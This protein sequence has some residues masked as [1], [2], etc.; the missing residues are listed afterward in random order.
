[1]PEAPAE[2]ADGELGSADLGPSVSTSTAG[3]RDSARNRSIGNASK[4][5]RTMVN[6]PKHRCL[7]GIRPVCNCPGI[8][9][10]V[11]SHNR[12]DPVSRCD[13]KIAG[14]EQRMQGMCVQLVSAIRHPIILQD[15]QEHN[16]HQ[17]LADPYGAQNDTGFARRHLPGLLAWRSLVCKE[18]L[19]RGVLPEGRQLRR[20]LSRN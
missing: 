9:G 1:M 4:M 18:G 20:H 19:L 17:E 14:A 16:R 15:G 2:T 3:A 11:P 12:T 10:P 8:H 6:L 7:T 13:C 5:K